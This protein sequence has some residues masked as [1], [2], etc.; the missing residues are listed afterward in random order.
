MN[1]IK[2]GRHCENVELQLL[3]YRWHNEKIVCGEAIMVTIYVLTLY[4]LII[5]LRHEGSHHIM[6]SLL[7]FCGVRKKM[8]SLGNVLVTIFQLCQGLKMAN[9]QGHMTALEHLITPCYPPFTAWK[10]LKMN[11]VSQNSGQIRHKSNIVCPALGCGES[12]CYEQCEL[13][14]DAPSCTSTEVTLNKRQR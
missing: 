8:L 6:V 7:P 12:T 1:P 3:N 9:S 11:H 2:L 14:V 10:K 13:P 5:M 4:G